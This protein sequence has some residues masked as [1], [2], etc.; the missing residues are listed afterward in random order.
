MISE[1]SILCCGYFS[2]VL[3]E[4]W[5]LEK[6]LGYLS[7]S[8]FLK[9]RQKQ[10]SRKLSVKGVHPFSK[11]HLN[12]WSGKPVKFCL[13]HL[14]FCFQFSKYWIIFKGLLICRQYLLKSHSD[15]DLMGL[16]GVF[17]FGSFGNFLPAKA[18]CSALQSFLKCWL[19]QEHQPQGRLCI[20]AGSLVQLNGTK[21]DG[22]WCT[23]ESLSCCPAE[24]VLLCCSFPFSSLPVSCCFSFALVWIQTGPFLFLVCSALTPS[25]SLPAHL[26]Y[27]RFLKAAA[28]CATTF[29]SGP[30]T[31]ITSY[32]SAWLLTPAPAQIYTIYSL[33][34]MQKKIVIKGFN[35][36]TFKKKC[37]RE[38]CIRRFL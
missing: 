26:F 10:Y 6:V 31:S 13:H 12:I 24:P 19:A 32:Y 17:L 3:W 20:R 18:L 7:G 30:T 9:W 5:D 8:I 23:S 28:T 38:L 22:W 4:H 27:H 34:L 15:L 33:C 25:S 36:D 16:P 1:L 37:K 21:A 35:Y 11:Y 14:P 29:F 2:P